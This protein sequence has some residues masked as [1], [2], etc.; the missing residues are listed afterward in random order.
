MLAWEGSCQPQFAALS[1][2]YTA[3]TGTSWSNSDGWLSGDPC[4]TGWFGVTCNNNLVVSLDLKNNNLVG[5]ISESIGNL[6][7]LKILKLRDNHLAGTIPWEAVVKLQGLE[8][9]WLNNNQLSGTIP[10]EIQTMGN[11]TE[12]DISDNAHSGTLPEFSLFS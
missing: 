12:F 1:S 9:F 10:I 6:T 8:I 5:S 7:G 4:S 2:F 3:S 11:L